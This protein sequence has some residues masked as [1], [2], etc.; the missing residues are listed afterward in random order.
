MKVD[1]SGIDLADLK[2]ELRARYGIDASVMTFVPKG[3]T[4]YGYRVDA[5]GASYFIRILPEAEGAR[6]EGVYGA[7]AQLRDGCGLK[8]ATPPLHGFNGSLT[9]RLAGHVVAVFTYL[10]EDI[11]WD[12]PGHAITSQELSK[13]ASAIVRLQA[14]RGVDLGRLKRE[15][16]AYPF[17]PGIEKAI[18]WAKS[19]QSP[20]DMVEAEVRELVIA[21][22][23]E[24]LDLLQRFETLGEALA[25]KGNAL[26]PS[27]SDPNLAN[28]I[29]GPD[30]S[31]H[32]IDWDELGL[33]PPEHDLWIQ[34]GARL[35]ETLSLTASTAVCRASM[36]T[37]STST[38]TIGLFRRSRPIPSASSSKSGHRTRS[39]APSPSYA[40][41]CRCAGMRSTGM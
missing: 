28:M 26:V 29:F 6:L 3:E 34:P 11:P 22:C 41:T 33:G 1:S 36:S 10:G 13:V 2:A 24:V 31:L 21:G 20:R 19:N 5:G 23:E 14:C 35:A 12:R 27:H 37:Y 18:S 9:F 7:L 15:T 8:E 16:F 39:R 38:A 25:A 17:R 32:L 40:T 4:S 30:G